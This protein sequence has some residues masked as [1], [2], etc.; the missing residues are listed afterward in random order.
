MPASET[1]ENDVAEICMSRPESINSMNS[2]FW[3]ELPLIIEALEAA[4]EQREPIFK[5]LQPDSSDTE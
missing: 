1:V 3:R 4:T 2:D 5:H